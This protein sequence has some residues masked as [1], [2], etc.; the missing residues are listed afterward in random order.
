MFRLQAWYHWSWYWYGWVSHNEVHPLFQQLRD[1]SSLVMHRICN[2]VP[3]LLQQEVL[4]EWY[5]YHWT[6]RLAEALGHKQLAPGDLLFMPGEQ[7]GREHGSEHL[8]ALTKQFSVDLKRFGSTKTLASKSSCL[9]FLLSFGSFAEPFK[10]SCMYF[11]TTG[12]LWYRRRLS[13]DSKVVSS[14]RIALRPNIICDTC[15]TLP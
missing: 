11:L 12:R 5:H 14:T 2:T 7:V 1:K 15:E 9:Y 8:M 6:P 10:A 3:W 4:A 13:T